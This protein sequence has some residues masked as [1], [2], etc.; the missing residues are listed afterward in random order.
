MISLPSVVVAFCS[1]LAMDL[2][3]IRAEPNLERRAHQALEHAAECFNEAK[4]A[5]AAGQV[6]R[7]GAQLQ[8]LQ[9]SVEVAYR[10][11]DQTGK[12]P[13]RHSH[14]FKMAETETHD[15]LRRME[16]LENTM[17]LD[18]RKLMDGPKAKVREVHD[19][20]LNGIISGRR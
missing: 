13:R 4:T 16:G 17:D 6:E 12:D 7:T 19:E 5:Y 18:D 15:L 9:D 20:W 10:A 14:P 11:L 8:E 3:A 1:M 2:S